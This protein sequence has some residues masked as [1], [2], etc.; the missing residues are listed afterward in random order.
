MSIHNTTCCG[1]KDYIG[2]NTYPTKRVLDEIA[3]IIQDEWKFR[4]VL[5]TDVSKGFKDSEKL[6]KLIKE[7]NLGDVAVSKPGM[8]P[9]TDNKLKVIVWK[10]NTRKLLSWH[11]KINKKA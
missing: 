8:N 1:V 7:N 10:V 3:L 6:I 9:V 4:F 2:L 11:R 5:F